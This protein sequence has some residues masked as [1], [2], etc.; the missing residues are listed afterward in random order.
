MAEQSQ[1]V[2]LMQRQVGMPSMK[3]QL[4]ESQTQELGRHRP[5]PWKEALQLHHAAQLQPVN[6]P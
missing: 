1:I 5:R 2:K 6:L 4:E 3:K